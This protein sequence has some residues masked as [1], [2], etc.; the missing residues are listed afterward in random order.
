L[1]QK[2][3]V[4]LRSLDVFVAAIDAGGMT[5]AAKRLGTTQSAVSQTIA[6]LEGAMGVQ[7]IDRTVRPP[8]LTVSGG[9]LYDRAKA[10]L[11]AAQEAVE[12]ARAPERHVLPHLR[13]GLV[14]SFAATIGPHLIRAM[15]GAAVHWSVWSGLSPEHE[16]SLLDREVDLIVAG[17]VGEDEEGLVRHHVLTEP[18]FLAVPRAYQG[19]TDDLNGLAQ[20]LDLVR[21]SARSTFGRKVERHL[22]RLRLAPPRRL[23][24]DTADAVIAMVGAGV[25]WAVTTPICFLQGLAHVRSVRCLPLPGPGFA[26]RLDL[27]ARQH[28]LGKLVE[29]LVTASTRVLEEHCLPVIAQHAPFAVEKMVLGGAE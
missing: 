2:P 16:R 8:K 23:E 26:R 7:L 27:I 3:I 21:Y 4:D 15:R 10:L 25:G 9:V 14:D 11:D 29:E 24:F 12:Q 17:D 1:V 19:P 5:A 20:R 6:N 13:V 18:F 28:E 22:R